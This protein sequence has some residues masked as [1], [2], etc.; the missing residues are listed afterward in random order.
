MRYMCP[1]TVIALS[2]SAASVMYGQGSLSITNYQMVSSQRISLT[3]FNVTY[4]ADLV[5]GG[6]ATNAMSVQVTSLVPSTV[7]VPG[8]DRLHFPPVPANGRATSLDT[9][10][11]MVDRTVTFDF[12][13]LVWTF[14]GPV[15]NGGP[16]QASSIGSTVT[17]SAAGSTDPAGSGLSYNWRIIA[18]PQ[19][20]TALLKNSQTV[21]PSFV[22]DAQGVYTLQLTVTNGVGSDVATVTVSTINTP[23]VANAGA[24]Q[25]VPVGTVVQLSGAGSSDVDGDS[26]TYAWTLMSWPAGST[27][28]L[29]STTAVTTSFTI[30]KPGTYTVQLVVN[31]GK[32]NSTPATVTIT[33]QNSPPVANAGTNQIITIGQLVH[34]DGSGSTDVDGDPLTYQWSLIHV[35][36]GSNAALDNPTAVKPAFTPDLSG[37]YVA[38]LIVNDGH[39]NSTPATVTLTTNAVQPPTANAGSGQT[40]DHYTVVQL[41]GSGTDPQGLP[42]NY[43]WSLTS[44]PPKSAAALSSTIIYNPTF[45]ADLPGTYVAQLIVDNGV[46]SSAP[47]TVTITTTNTAPVANPGG[48]QTVNVGA[49]VTLDGTGSSDADHDPLTYKWSMLSVPTLS[50]ALISQPNIASPTFF[51]DMAGMYVVQLIVNDGFTDSPPVTATITANAL[52]PITLTPN[53]LNL[54]NV[55]AGTLTLTLPSPAGAS[56]L[57]VNLTS[58]DSTIASVPATVTVPANS[59][60]VLVTVTPGINTGSVQIGAG[61]AGFPPGAAIV[62]V[63]V[64]GIGINLDSTTIGMTTTVNGTITLSAPAPANGVTITLSANPTGT[65]DVELPSFL[66]PSGVSS[67]TFAVKG[68]APGS[69]TITAS[70]PNYTSGSIGVSVIMLGAIGLPSGVSV[71][72]GQ[73]MA[74]PVNLAT[75]APP[76]G[77]NILLNSSDSTIVSISPTTVSIAAGATTPSVQPQITGLKLGSVLIS[78]SAPGFTGDTETVTVVSAGVIG[79]PPSS[80]VQLGQ[81]ATFAITLPSAAPSGGVT[82]QLSSSD[83]SKVTI[84]PASVSIAGG[85]T[86]PSSQ[87]QVT[88]KSLGTANITASASGYTSASAPV[89]VNASLTYSPTSLTINGPTSQ[90]ITITLSATTPVAVILNLTS[91]NTGVATVPAT[92]TIP[93]NGN[94]VSVSVTGIS[95]GST[96][97]HASSLPNIPD[98]T[99]NV[100]VTSAAAIG[101]PSNGTVQLGQ[102]A[103]FAITLPSPAPANGVTVQLASSDGSKVTISPASVSIA[104]GAT[105]PGTQP[106]VTG[107]SLGTANITASATG[108]TTASA[109]VQVNATIAYSP[110]SLTING[111]TSQN[112]TITLSATTPVP[113]ALALT[114]DNT[115]VATVPAT[116]TI[117]ANGNSVSVSVTGI[118]LGSTKIHA[119]SLPNI[120]D[121]SANVTVASGGSIVLPVST[122]VA[123][124]QSTPFTVTL[125]SAA[126]PNGVTVQLASSDG[127]KVTIS[128]ASVSIA[129]GATTSFSQAQVTGVSLGTANITASATGY[130]TASAPVQVNATLTYSPT[131]LTINGLTSQSITITLSATTP[132]PVVLNLTS[133]NTAVAT[134]PATA[135]IPANGN[136]VS[137]S[138]SGIALGST[139]IHA[140]SLPN[141]PD[142]TA[143]VTVVNAGSIILPSSTPVALGQSAPFTVTLPSAAPANGVTVQLSSGD[144]SKVTISPASVT[145]AA[146]ATTPSAQPQVTGVSLGTANITASATGYTT[147]VGPVQVNATVTYSPTSLTINGF[148]SQNITITLSA[149]TPV[150]VILNLTSDNTAIATVPATA[151]IPAN[152][153]S[154]SVSVSGIALGSTVIHASS[155]PNIPDTTA[156][157]SVVSAGT[158]NVPSST[159]VALGQSTAFTVTLPWAAPASGVTVQLASSDGSK[160][161]ISPTSVTIAAGAT[162]PSAQPQVT[163]K[164]IGTAN[165]TASAPGYTSASGP[166]Q[167]NASLTY[168]PTSLTINGLT[169]QNITITLS[170]TTPVPVILNLTS[171]N[172]AVATVPAT[173]TI[174]ANGNSVTV[175]VTGISLGST[176]IHASST[177]NIPDA[178]APVTVQ[179]AGTINLPSNVSLGLG[180]AAAFP[181]SLSAATTSDLTVT[182]SSSDPTVVS[183]SVASVLI[184]AGST[185]PSSQPQVTGKNVGTVTISATAPGYLKTT[186]SVPVTA[187]LSFVP[188]TLTLAA[189]AQQSL[190]LNLS[191]PAPTGGLIVNLSSSNTAAATVPPTAT[192]AA[193]GSSVSVLVT[194]VATG[195]TVIHASTSNIPDTTANV[196]VIP[197]PDFI[198]PTG[199]AVAA[200]QNVAFMVTLSKPAPEGGVFVSMTSS[201]TTILAVQ[202]SSFMIGSGRTTPLITP[203]LLGVATGSATITV[204]AYGLTSAT[205]TVT[206]GY[207]FSFSP[208]SLSIELLAHAFRLRT[209]QRIDHQPEFE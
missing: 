119:S 178:S 208:T 192:I 152:G 134:V 127:S 179:P 144:G 13:N 116:A 111:L 151:T 64:P 113:V 165:I 65:V 76:A 205:A 163:G 75:P 54:T 197:V 186:Q 100:T 47:S 172:T 53:P 40:V 19:G 115:G 95:A 118:S 5:N 72:P 34:L 164:S 105:T 161:T 73:S 107:V 180:Q 176:A 166:V 68:T 199:V 194:G 22:V 74:F 137:V 184:P 99:A 187:T 158:I 87:P 11:I 1:A 67:G 85:A 23:P 37:S 155:L 143:N 129:A 97:I 20:S 10:T 89:Q 133:D 43:H 177:P 71:G 139:K 202:T 38:Q 25:T 126:P 21:A 36:S 108:Y 91:D 101:M 17:L 191:G 153:N 162:A 196:T 82:V 66:I 106:Q 174:P 7:P 77:V 56:G 183:L 96:L 190:T 148:T 86:T 112:I 46:L 204:S 173:A 103:T 51:A 50:T 120:P 33:T 42:L 35:P 140:S 185:T 8:E 98:A 55:A 200:G 188:S 132:V 123:L 156:N 81:A 109:P 207:V 83:G 142:T 167:V 128:P 3:Q 102:A 30:D 131:S 49:T 4:Q 147:A 79:I 45:Y 189:N 69:T 90:N 18:R 135:T 124:G 171:D 57:V 63:A 141:I 206:V 24:N 198:L 80:T 125:P 154:V 78:A 181:V 169:S 12:A 145:I 39:V 16:N 15:A 48:N 2:I 130:T 159:P 160:V 170:A 182:L 195:T 203:Q 193:G 110:T 70:A 93:A 28:S 157:V 29:T 146:G 117:P 209:Y 52:Q 27:A 41:S 175:P 26:L 149:T 31:D 9:F 168:S 136:S 59:T 44:V 62:N 32:V 92:A 150:P 58:T 104:A 84:S 94:S 121:T 60:T 138:V 122:A 201:D 14:G 61:A 114:S 88:G 6:R